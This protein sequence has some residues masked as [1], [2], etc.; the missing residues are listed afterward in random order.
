MRKFYS[1]ILACILIALM[2]VSTIAMST[3][4]KASTASPLSYYEMS[5]SFKDSCSIGRSFDKIFLDVRLMATADNGN[6]ERVTLEVYVINT[7]KT[8]TYT[9]YTDGLTQVFNNIYLGLSGG[10]SVAFRFR[11]DNPNVTINVNM[12]AES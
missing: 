6:S 7:N 1:K 8:K 5:F 11:A 12:S 3:P 9:F 10:S 4:V 2:M